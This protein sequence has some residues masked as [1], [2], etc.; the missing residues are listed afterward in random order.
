MLLDRR[1]ERR[2]MDRLLDNVRAGHSEALVVRGDA[3][4]GK[5]ALLEYLLAQ[6]SA[7]RVARAAGVQAEQE[8]AFAAVPCAR[9]RL[10]QRTRVVVDPTSTVLLSDTLLPGRVAYGESHAYDLY[11]SELEVYDAGHGELLFA[12]AQRIRPAGDA[13]PRSPAILGGYAVLA[14][15][16]VVTRKVSPAELIAVLRSAQTDSGVLVGATGL[17]NGCGVTVRVLGDKAEQVRTQLR[18]AWDRVRRLL[19]GCGAPELRKG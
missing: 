1:T 8:L 18:L 4:V 16:H 5:T 9:S 2:V 19:V 17:P 6:A 7:C 14:N 15:F 13:D 11:W 3:G 10:F 12:D